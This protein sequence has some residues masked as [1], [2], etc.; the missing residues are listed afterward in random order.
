[1]YLLISHRSLFYLQHVDTVVFS[2]AVNFGLAAEA[3][4]LGLFVG[5]KE[6][7]VPD[8][9]G[10]EFVSVVGGMETV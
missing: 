4:G 6:E 3:V 8:G 2:G 9:F 5:G 7:V 10:E 1:M